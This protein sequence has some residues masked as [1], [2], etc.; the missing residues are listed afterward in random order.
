M[1]KPKK[2]ALVLSGGGAK[3]FAHMGILKGLDEAGFPK[4]SLIAGTSMGAIIGG[5]YACGMSAAEMIDFVCN[6][7]KFS[8]YL[9][10]FTFKMGGLAGKVFQTGQ[11]LAN[12]ATRPG[13]DRG[14]KVLGLLER[15]T[16]GKQF[17]ETEIPFRCNAV[18]LLS[19]KEVV[20]KSGSVAKAI[21]ASMSFP[22]FF[23]PVE[24]DGMYLVDGGVLNNVP[25]AAVREEGLKNV[26][27]VNVSPFAARE[28][29][30]FN[31][32]PQIVFR[33][34]DSVIRAL[35]TEKNIDVDF[36]INITNDISS[37]SFSRREELIELG[38]RAV[39][40]NMEALKNFF[41]RRFSF[42]R[43]PVVC[44]I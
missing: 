38:E 40:E 22:L 24:E 35:D 11:T 21:R 43:K 31:N 41:G 26:L 23:E 12:L 20:F 13:L 19:G 7:F 3:G 30:D 10:S 16:K 25:A 14:Q 5:V 34:F 4:P 1:S 2:W 29:K 37:F 18:D 27:A 39:K 17:D 8:D 33:C 36:T 44:N 6:E 28:R 15:L 9:E 42:F 32:G